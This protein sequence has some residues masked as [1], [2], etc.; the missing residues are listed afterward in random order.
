ME[1]VHVSAECYPVAKAGGL[2]D[3]VG[4]LPRYQEREGH[5]CKV[6]MPMYRV[7]FL[8]D[9]EWDL[10][11]KGE[12][13]LGNNLF[14]YSIIKEKNRIT[15][16]DLFLVD[17]NGLLDR[18]R[19][20]GY[21]DDIE[22]FV[23]FQIAVTDWISKWVHR[24]DIIHV[25]DH[26]TAL[27][28]FMMQHC[29]AYHHLASIPTILTVHNAQYQGW[30]GWEKQ[31]LIPAFDSWKG[32]LLDWSGSINSLATGIKCAWKVTT[33]SWSYL[34]ELQ[35]QANGLELLFSAEKAKCSGI[36]NGIDTEVWNPATD[37]FLKKK[38]SVENFRKGKE[39]NKKLICREFSLD[40]AKPL[41]VFIG[42]LV[43]EKAADILPEAIMDA[44]Q[45]IGRELNIMV[46][47]SGEPGIE[48]KLLSLKSISQNDYAVHIGYNEVLSHQL[49]A[50]AD[51]LLM[52]SR[53]EPCGLNQMY[54]MKYGTV[55]LVRNTGG[56][57]DTI[58][59]INEWQGYGIK[60][61]HADVGDLTH[62]LFRALNLY[63]DQKNMDEIVSY[64]MH[65][66]FSWGKSAKQYLD[67][68]ESVI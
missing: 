60:F 16:F 52:P 40:P 31:Y 7:K 50:G 63:K 44:F 35:Q 23:A 28:P 1:I 41:F 13:L 21:P 65:L 64:M 59:D 46:L 20:Y 2:A 9:N 55:P 3:V 15:G 57:K 14:Q 62:A 38:Y 48:E 10:A 25:H 58:I 17:I 66:D 47:G 67:L 68:Y 56:L 11:H 37:N 49:Y 61:E 5:T 30:I 6:V 8:S 43:G 36:L 27:I 24:P 22:R 34:E 18:E 19:I 33:V 53:V 12:A 39:A 51:F 29:Y 42:R 45:Y 54:S 26:H 32:G 4:A